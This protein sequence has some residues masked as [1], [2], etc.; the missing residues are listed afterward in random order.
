MRL[1]PFSENDPPDLVNRLV[2]WAMIHPKDPDR[3]FECFVKE[4]LV[5]GGKVYE[6][7]NSE[8][9]N[10]PAAWVKALLNGP[11]YKELKSGVEVK[12]RQGITAGIILLS[13]RACA[14][15]G[16]PLSL[17]TAIEVL[18][19][20]DLE[21]ATG[22]FMGAKPY[23]NKA[24]IHKAWKAMCSVAHLWAAF[25]LADLAANAGVRTWD[26]GLIR[27]G[28]GMAASLFEWACETRFKA[29]GQPLI[30][31]TE[32]WHVPM[33]VDKIP[34]APVRREGLST[35]LIEAIERTVK[36]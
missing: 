9:V 16:R 26:S 31:A 20:A 22:P 4:Q 15:L 19:R 13:L 25:L 11:S 33:F 5:H 28:L 29:S 2:W 12:T 17:N 24:E 23:G 34:L 18:T 6:L 3:A 27:E 32:A 7:P 30:D 1:L 10:I 8:V 21:R 14:G 36:R 35:W